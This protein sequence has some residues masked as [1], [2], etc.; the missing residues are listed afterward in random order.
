M[1]LL[2]M[3]DML[4]EKQESMSIFSLIGFVYLLTAM[5][6]LS[7]TIILR[8]DLEKKN[9]VFSNKTMSLSVLLADT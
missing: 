7:N 3:P 2:Q 5:N 8:T 6:S 4:M 1:N 9:Y